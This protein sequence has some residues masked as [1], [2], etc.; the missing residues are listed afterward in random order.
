MASLSDFFATYQL[1]NI[2]PTFTSQFI[3]CPANFDL[4][5]DGNQDWLVLGGNFPGGSLINTPQPG[6]LLLGDG[7]GGF[8]VAPESMFPNSALNTVHPRKVLSGDLNGDGYLDVFVSNHGWDTDPFPGE[9]NRLFL[10]N[11]DGTWRNASSNLPQLSDFSHTAAIG[12]INGDGKL[13]IFVGNGYA[14]QNHIF[15]Y[16]LLNNGQGAFTQTRDIIPGP[17]SILDF[18]SQG[19]VHHFPGATL[20]DLNGDGLPELLICADAAASYDLNR[21]SAI[22]W[23]QNGVFSENNMTLLPQTTAFSSHIDTDIEP[24]DINGDGLKD[25]IIIGTQGQPAFYDG[26][27]VQLLLNEGNKNFVDMT[28]TYLS[29]SGAMGGSE[30]LA[31]QT[32]WPLWVQVLD[33]NRDGFSDFAIEFNGGELKQSTPLVWL[34]DGTGHFSTLK[35]SDFVAPGEEYLLGDGRLYPTD[36]GYS[37]VATQVYSGSNGLLLSGL[38]ASKAYTNTLASDGSALLFGDNGNDSLTGGSGNDNING[39]AG[40]DA[41]VF[42]AGHQNYTVS[43]ANGV[44]TVTDK[45]GVEGSDTLSNIEVLQ[46][47]DSTQVIT[48]ANSALAYAALLYQGALGRTPDPTGL[49]YW[50]NLVASVMGSQQSLGLYALSDTSGNYNGQLSIA[51]GFTHSA[52]FVGKYGSLTDSQFITQLYSNILDRAPDDAGLNAWVAQLAGGGTRE[53]A[54]V[55]FA[56]SSEA[57]NNASIGFVGQTGTQHDAWL[58]LN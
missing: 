24:I 25:L 36:N 42:R 11:G 41:A 45:T 55:G 14:G 27:F 43:R 54:L 3:Y 58:L 23:N 20:T 34:N 39:G 38:V 35:V 56:E 7:R 26:Y 16:V 4:N 51:A 46:F 19:G 6:R 57:I 29:G 33:F 44:L 40:I 9:Q 5:R 32:L 8:T 28:S 22:L 2:D 48:P 21:Q 49:A 30:G 31:T 17:N 37:F 52:E 50:H 13:D 15:S 10:S 18:D 1:T 47:S 12:D 53:H